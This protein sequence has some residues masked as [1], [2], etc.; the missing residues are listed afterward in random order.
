MATLETVLKITGQFE[1]VLA[2]QLRS[3]YGSKAELARIT[4]ERLQVS[5]QLL[6]EKRKAT[7]QEP[8]KTD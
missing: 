4:Y 7:D 3:G 8:G 1:A 2:A 5:I 6:E